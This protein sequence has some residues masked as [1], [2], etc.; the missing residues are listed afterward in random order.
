MTNRRRSL[1]LMAICCIVLASCGIATVRESIGT[2]WFYPTDDVVSE[3]R[4]SGKPEPGPWTAHQGM[5]SVVG[6][7]IVVEP[8]SSITLEIEDECFSFG[9]GTHTIDASQGRQVACD[10]DDDDQDD[11]RDDEDRRSRDDTSNTNTTTQHG[12]LETVKTAVTSTTG[13]VVTSAIVGGLL[14]EHIEDNRKG[15]PVSP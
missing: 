8:G 3:A 14:Y 5:Q 15:D 11:D 7:K 10:D 2:T 1:W 13:I 12:V 4:K 9:P 6:R